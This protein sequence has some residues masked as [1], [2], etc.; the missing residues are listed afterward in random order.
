MAQTGVVN[1]QG[2]RETYVGVAGVD[3]EDVVIETNDIGNYDTFLLKNGAGA[4]EVMV[5]LGDGVFV[6]PHSVADLGA[7][8]SDPVVVTAAG[9]A[10]GFRGNFHRIQVLQTGATAATDAVLRLYRS[11]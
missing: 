4:V 11:K 7:I 3:D 5:D 2:D 10:Y 1:N 8:D 9:R 6:G